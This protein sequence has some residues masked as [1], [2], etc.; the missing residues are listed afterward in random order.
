M[1]VTTALV[2]IAEDDAPVLDAPVPCHYHQTNSHGDTDGTLT[3]VGD[4]LALAAPVV[5]VT[6]PPGV[7]VAAPPAE[8]SLPPVVVAP[9]PEPPE[10]PPAVSGCEVSRDIQYNGTR[11]NQK[12]A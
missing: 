4:P 7:G 3:E 9:D 8:D 11:S 1:G 6:A 10:P 12:G 2:V 5:G